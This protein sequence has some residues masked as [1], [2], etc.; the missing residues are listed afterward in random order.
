[1]VFVC[2]AGGVVLI[3]PAFAICLRAS[4]VGVFAFAL[5]SALR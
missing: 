5:A 2:D 1:M 4:L 3:L